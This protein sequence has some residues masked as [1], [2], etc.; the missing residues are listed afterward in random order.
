MLCVLLLLLLQEAVRV[1]HGE[2]PGVPRHRTAVEGGPGTLHR[3]PVRV[4]EQSGVQHQG[5]LWDSSQG[6]EGEQEIGALS[7]RWGIY[8]REPRCVQ[9]TA[10]REREGEEEEEL[11][12]PAPHP[13]CQS[14]SNLFLLRFFLFLFILTTYIYV[15]NVCKHALLLFFSLLHTD[16]VFCVIFFYLK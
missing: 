9:H 4:H 1:Y 13:L 8:D 16:I 10:V 7:G 3:Q 2:Q 11:Q 14:H 12:S 6:G 5:V 15:Y